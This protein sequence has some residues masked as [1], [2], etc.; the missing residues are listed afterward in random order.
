MLEL[1]CSGLFTILGVFIGWFLNQ[2]S[3]ARQS[4]PRLCFSLCNTPKSE[5]IEKELRTKTSDSDYGIEIYN[6]G[7]TPFILNYFELCHKK[8]LLVDCRPSEQD[9]RI[10]PY[11]S[12]TYTLME[13]GSESLEW[14]CK[15]KDFSYCKVIAYSI[16][17]KRVTGKLEI[18]LIQLRASFARELDSGAYIVGKRA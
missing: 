6:V 1:V 9:R 15:E 2:F 11:Q 5:L 3:T 13:Q 14:H 4:R 18:P 7:Q 16:D 17:G 12:I 8:D 10:L